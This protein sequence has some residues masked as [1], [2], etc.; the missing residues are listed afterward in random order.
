MGRRT[1]ADG[2]SLILESLEE[3]WSGCCACFG[4]WKWRGTGCRGLFGAPGMRGTSFSVNCAAWERHSNGCGALRTLNYRRQRVLRQF[5]ALNGP[6]HHSRAG[7]H[8]I[9]LAAPT[10]AHTCPNPGMETTDDRP[11]E[12]HALLVF[13]PLHLSGAIEFL[14]G[15]EDAAAGADGLLGRLAGVELMRVS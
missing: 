2:L 9:K 15:V 8:V 6:L 13:R 5:Q 3:S 12:Q 1:A 4:G 11:T 7:F 14:D 10:L